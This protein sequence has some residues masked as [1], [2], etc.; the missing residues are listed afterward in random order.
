[1][2]N[3]FN[4]ALKARKTRQQTADYF[5]SGTNYGDVLKEKVSGFFGGGD[6]SKSPEREAIKRKQAMSNG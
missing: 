4:D 3:V 1:M 5:K 2:D 6:K